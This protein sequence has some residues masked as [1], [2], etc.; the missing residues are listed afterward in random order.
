MGASFVKRARYKLNFWDSALCDGSDVAVAM[1]A[2]RRAIA[3]AA[4]LHVRPLVAPPR[5]GLGSGIVLPGSPRALQD[6]AK[7]EMLESEEPAR[8]G[9]IWDAFHA[10]QEHVAGSTLS[11]EVADSIVE[12]GGE[13]PN[14]VFPLRRGGG[15]FMLFSQFAPAHRM[16]VFT[17]LEDYRRA[18]EMAQPWA[19]GTDST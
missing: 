17:F 12:R 15:H 8:I 6:V 7:L 4:R 2:C 13:S 11:P 19:V 3:S 16:F 1:I 9:A 18:P 10:E 14:F 5:R